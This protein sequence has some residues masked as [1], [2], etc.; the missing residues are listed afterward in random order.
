MLTDTPPYVADVLESAAK[1][2]EQPGKWVQ[3]ENALDKFGE[4]TEPGYS[5]AACWCLEGALQQC[6]GR[7]SAYQA[8]RRAVGESNLWG[9]ND[10]PERTQPE[11]VAAL[12]RAATLARAGDA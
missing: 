3:G 5:D 11:V 1:L 9:W 2:I 12:R 10:A 8:V 6:G 4:P 7:H